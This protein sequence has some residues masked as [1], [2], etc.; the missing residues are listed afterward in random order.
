MN[1]DTAFII[2]GLNS[3]S[4]IEEVES[5]YKELA[6]EKHPD[7]GG[8]HAVMAELSEARDVLRE[9]LSS[10]NLPAVIKQFELAVHNMNE[11]ARN[12]RNVEKRIERITKDIREIATIRLRKWRQLAIVL[13]G[14]SAAAMFIGK[15]LPK[16][17]LGSFQL[18][19]KTS[20]SPAVARPTEPDFVAPLKETKEMNE[21]EFKSLALQNKEI[22]AK[23]QRRYIQYR[24]EVEKVEAW[25]KEI[26]ERNRQYMLVWYAGTFGIGIYAGFIAWYFNRRIER[27]EIEIS[28]LDEDLTSKST[29]YCLL[30]EI[31][32]VSIQEKWTFVDLEECMHS[33]KPSRESWS[34]IFHAIGAKKFA[35]LL[36]SK[37]QEIGL[38]ETIAGSSE[39]AFEEK[40]FIDH[41]EKT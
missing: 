41:T 30:N 22:K 8:D 13:A 32:K 21:E 33:W 36:I 12:Q 20:P 16:E 6:V 38:I 31:L 10:K 7:R 5:A 40:Y 9:H 34:T 39:S 35:H 24:S 25:N 3:S 29:F 1:I 11:L 17:L 2:L 14:I 18:E 37:G 4:A 19:A 15:D 26:K 27:V 28:D 23:N